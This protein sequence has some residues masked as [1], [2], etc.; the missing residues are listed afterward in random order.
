MIR[1]GWIALVGAIAALAA[2][3]AVAAADS[4]VFIKDGNV[5]IAA[6]DGSKASQLTTDGG[7][8]SPS[9]SD[10]GTI[11]AGRKMV[12]DG[13]TVRR[14]YRMDTNGRLLNAPVKTFADNDVYIGPLGPAISPDG[15]RVAFYFFNQGTL[16]SSNY[17]YVAFGASDSDTSESDLSQRVGY[18]LNPSWIDNNTILLLSIPGYTMNV[19]TYTVGGAV[20]DWF[21]EPDGDLGAGADVSPDG[22]KM[23]GELAPD[24]LRLYSLNGPPPAPPT[25]R[26]DIGGPTGR[27]H[28][29]PNYAP[30]SNGVTWAEDDGIHVGRFN[31][32]DCSGGSNLVIPGGDQ[33]YWGPADPPAAQSTGG[34]LKL[35]ISA[36]RAKLGKALAHGYSFRITCNHLCA[37]AAELRLHGKQVAK[38]GLR[39][40]GPGGIK[41][42]VKFTKAGRA[43]LR[44]KKRV[45]LRL[46]VAA[47][48]PASHRASAGRTVVLTR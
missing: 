14:L 40:G 13:R 38:G 22:T 2:I 6:P 10:N 41:Y 26:C 45:S 1:K 12:V 3:P 25:A 15:R 16:E 23:I 48:D 35:S 24:K 39:K 9:E 31:L 36:K 34:A 19:Q 20:H 5:W 33:P 8:E 18:Y 29:K 37:A 7:Y 27:F 44:S 17:P 46:G 43:I 11:M 30:D 32:S 28:I 47:V 21:N 42:V 4:I